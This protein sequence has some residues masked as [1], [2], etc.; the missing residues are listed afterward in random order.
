MLHIILNRVAK[1]FNFH[2]ATVSIRVD[3]VIKSD[4]CSISHCKIL[5]RVVPSTLNNS[6]VDKSELKQLGCT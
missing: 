6:W 1:L 2:G 3:Y 4:A 5:I